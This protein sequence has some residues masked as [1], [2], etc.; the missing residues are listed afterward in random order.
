MH[1]DPE[2]RQRCVR[3]CLYYVSM[4]LRRLR[5]HIVGPH[6]AQV[7]M[8]SMGIEHEPR[9]VS[10]PSRGLLSCQP[11]HMGP[12]SVLTVLQIGLKLIWIGG[13]SP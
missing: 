10:L 11:W 3:T 13:M 8:S 4:G 2:D 5:I 7:G 9:V 6:I 12:G 1:S